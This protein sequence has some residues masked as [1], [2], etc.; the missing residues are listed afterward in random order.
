MKIIG[1]IPARYA[2]S[3]FPGKPLADICGKPMIWWV[4]NNAIRSEILN[5]VIVALDDVR[6]AECCVKYNIN[7]IMTSPNHDTPTSRLHEVSMKNNADL[8]IMIMGDEPLINH[9][10]FLLLLPQYDMPNHY[11]AVLTNVVSTPT[12]VIDY[13]NQKV[14]IN[15]ENKALFISRSPIPYPKGTLDFEYKKVTGL[16]AYNQNALEFFATTAKS[17]LE[18][19]EECDLMRF[20]ENNIQVVAIHSPYKTVSVDFQKDLDEVRKIISERGNFSSE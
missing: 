10:A 1:V 4:Y 6:I 13:T 18:Q 15:S 17:K 16:Q 7:Y 3:R 5:D 19:A 9:K 14:V 20:I 8:Y 11:V 12:E 2:S